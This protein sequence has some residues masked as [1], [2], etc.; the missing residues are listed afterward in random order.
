MYFTPDLMVSVQTGGHF[1][2]EQP[3]GTGQKASGTSLHSLK[4]NST[5]VQHEG[6]PPNMAHC[7]A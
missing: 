7:S 5:Q 1:M 4:R 3:I 2:L 6:M